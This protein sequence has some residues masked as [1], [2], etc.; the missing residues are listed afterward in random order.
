MVPHDLLPCEEDFQYQMGRGRFQWVLPPFYQEPLGALSAAGVG[1]SKSRSSIPVLRKT[2]VNFN[3]LV[4]TMC[5][6]VRPTPSPVVSGNGRPFSW[7]WMWLWAGGWRADRLDAPPHFITPCRGLWRAQGSGVQCC[8]QGPDAAVQ[9]EEEQ[10]RL[11][12][13]WLH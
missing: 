3:S 9:S 4:E 8:A 13:P 5:I 11:C 12:A 7:S 10:G 2:Y 6:E 1:L